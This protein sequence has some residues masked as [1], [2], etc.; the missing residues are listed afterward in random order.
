MTGYWR[1]TH[2]TKSNMLIS[3]KSSI[4]RAKSHVKPRKGKMEVKRTYLW[5][6]ICYILGKESADQLSIG[7]DLAVHLLIRIHPVLSHSWNKTTS[8]ILRSETSYCYTVDL[9]VFCKGRNDIIC[10]LCCVWEKTGLNFLWT[11][12][13]TA[14]FDTWSIT[15]PKYEEVMTAAFWCLTGI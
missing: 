8:L 13:P 7:E 3:K 2:F 12:W 10:R 5:G 14:D 9:I 11:F 6:R 1:L 4:R 15:Y